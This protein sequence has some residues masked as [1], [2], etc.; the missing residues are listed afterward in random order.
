MAS[1]KHPKASVNQ[2]EST[3]LAQRLDSE[4]VKTIN[5]KQTYALINSILPFEACLYYQVLPLYIEGKRL[6]IGS[7]N[8]QD[9]EAV[10][11]VRK[12][13]SY[14]NYSI[15]FQKIPSD[16]HRDL[17]SKYLNYTSK[18]GQPSPQEI[19]AHLDQAPVTSQPQDSHPLESRSCQATFII[20]QPDELLD[21]EQFHPLSHRQSEPTLAVE[22]TSG[23][24]KDKREDYP[25]STN[26]V[27]H[28][29]ASAGLEE[30]LSNA[31]DTVPSSQPEQPSEA[32]SSPLD[33]NLDPQY[34]EIASAQLCNLPPHALMQALLYQV[35]DEG[36]GRLYFERQRHS[37]RILWSR[38][39][40]LQAVLESIDAP[41]IQAVIDEFKALTRLSLPTAKQSQSL[42]I[43]RTHDSQRVLLRFRLIPNVHG[44]EATLQVLRGTALRFYQQQQIERLGK[45]ALDTAHRLQQRLDEIRDRARSA[46]SSKAA[47]SPSLPALIQL[48]KQME[49]QVEEIIATYD[50]KSA[51]VTASDKRSPDSD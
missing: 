3:T 25:V 18:K 34:R 41:L 27:F 33:L 23:F 21:Y 10:E 32:E 6:V 4:V 43:E 48:L 5:L 39:G 30:P 2:V 16:W 19:T 15:R 42:E 40:I 9:L 36:I 1:F 31:S 24:A 35:L 22:S 26:E 28:H 38:D 20:D 50:F 37:G 29:S 11:Y 49:M 13:L 12:Q 14:I 46:L 45:D 51:A 8:P 7:V 17:L 47:Q 44:E